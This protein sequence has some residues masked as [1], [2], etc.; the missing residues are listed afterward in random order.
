MKVFLTCFAVAIHC[1]IALP[2][3]AQLPA[4]PFNTSE[5]DGVLPYNQTNSTKDSVTTAPMYVDGVTKE[6]VLPVDPWAN[7]RDRSGIE[8]WRGSGQHGRLNYVGEA[9]TYTEAQGQEMI[10][11]EV[12]RHNMIVALKHLRGLGYH[13]PSDYDEGIRNLPSAYK[14]K[15]NSSMQVVQ[16]SSNPIHKMVRKFMQLFEN[17]T[18]LDLGNILSTSMRL[19]GID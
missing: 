8:T 14:N 9:T 16:T 19:L 7:A 17:A 10:A 13:I 2:A 4:N 18:G 15:L 3:M 5:N 6:A 11:P 1:V 12:N